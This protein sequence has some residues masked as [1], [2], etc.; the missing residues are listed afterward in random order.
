VAQR[1]TDTTYIAECFWPDVH[2]ESVEEATQRIRQS[3][4]E[5]TRAGIEVNLNDTILLPGDEV[6][7]YLFSGSAEAVRE[8]CE[9]AEIRFERVVESVHGVMKPPGEER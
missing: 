9:R 3:V 6:V 4:A 8:A 7:F 1:P 2:R 5:L